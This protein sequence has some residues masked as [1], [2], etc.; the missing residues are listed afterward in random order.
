MGDT[1]FRLPSNPAQ[2][3]TSDL[4]PPDAFTTGDKTELIRHIIEA[5][6]RTDLERSTR[7]Q[8]HS[9]ISDSKWAQESGVK[10]MT[11][12]AMRRRLSTS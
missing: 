3:A 6:G 11:M 2:M 12:V 10:C 8:T 7:L 1:D 9:S 5:E 4:T